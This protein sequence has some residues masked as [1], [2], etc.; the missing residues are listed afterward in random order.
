MIAKSIN[1]KNNKEVYLL[2]DAE[3][4]LTELLVHKDRV[5]LYN[6]LGGHLEKMDCVAHKKISI[7]NLAWFFKALFLR[8]KFCSSKTSSSALAFWLLL[9]S[10][11]SLAL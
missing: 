1:E 4:A 9:S 7:M 10:S 11:S 2:N 6:V 3:L 5:C 8:L